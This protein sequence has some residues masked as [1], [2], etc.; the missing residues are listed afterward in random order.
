LYGQT[1]VFALF[2]PRKE[3]MEEPD[4][5]LNII[6]DDKKAAIKSGTT[7]LNAARR[8]GIDIPTLCYHPALE[9][10]GVCRVCIVEI[11]RG[12]RTRVVTSCNYPIQDDGLEIFTNSERIKRDR[13]M[14]IEL[15]LARCWSSKVIREFAAK[16]GI[17]DTELQKTENEECI[18][19]GLCVNVCRDLIGQSAIGFESRGV[20]RKTSVPFR[21]PNDACI[22]CGACVYVCPTGCIKLED[23]P[24]ERVIERWRSEIPVLVCKSCGRGFGTVKQLEVL[25]NKNP[26]AKFYLEKCPKC[27]EKELA[28]VMVRK[29]GF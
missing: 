3:K 25:K 17:T 4:K 6:I 7:I 11:K 19:C 9:P 13:K 8:A 12:K 27:R 5:I 2:A 26:L 29:G 21:K 15:L 16:Y 20:D 24:E 28:E 18:L 22:G 14:V 1:R 10:Y 23:L